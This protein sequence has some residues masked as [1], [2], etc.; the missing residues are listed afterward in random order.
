V[1]GDFDIYELY[2]ADQ[3]AKLKQNNWVYGKL[4][5]TKIVSPLPNHYKINHTLKVTYNKNNISIN[6]DP[7]MLMKNKQNSFLNWDCSIGDKNMRVDYDLIYRGVCEVGGS[8]HIDDKIQFTDDYVKCDK[9]QCVCGTDMIA[10]KILKESSY[11][12]E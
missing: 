7:Q 4:R 1:F 3:L 8:I 12:N 2:T 10:T 9:A 11:T 5:S 6:I